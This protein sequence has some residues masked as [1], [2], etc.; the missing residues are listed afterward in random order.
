LAQRGSERNPIVK[1]A[2]ESRAWLIIPLLPRKRLKTIA[3]TAGATTRGRMYPVRIVFF[4]F[5]YPESRRT[6]STSEI[7]TCKGIVMIEMITVT[8]KES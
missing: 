3:R 2:S 4:I 8:P 7:M 6:A 5:V 1:P